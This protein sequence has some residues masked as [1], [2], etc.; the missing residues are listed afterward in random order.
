MLCWFK[1]CSSEFP[2]ELIAA[3]ALR[4]AVCRGVPAHWRDRRRYVVSVRAAQRDGAQIYSEPRV[5]L[6]PSVVP[7]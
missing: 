3:L 6:L 2:L 1:K 7:L 4:E 5:A